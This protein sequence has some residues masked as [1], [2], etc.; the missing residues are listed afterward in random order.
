ME[1]AHKEGVDTAERLDCW[2]ERG[3]LRVERS[4]AVLVRN[5]AALRRQHARQSQ[6]RQASP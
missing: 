5:A 2:A 6:S 3:A 4:A 1:L